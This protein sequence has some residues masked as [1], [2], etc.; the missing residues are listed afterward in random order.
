MH[1]QPNLDMYLGSC[2]RSALLSQ[3]VLLPRLTLSL[4]AAQYKYFEPMELRRV[5][6]SS[7]P[8]LSNRESLFALSQ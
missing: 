4:H 7:K 3:L 1:F 5:R 2:M 6:R 8:I